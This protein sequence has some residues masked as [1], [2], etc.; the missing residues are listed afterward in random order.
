MEYVKELKPES[1]GNTAFHVA[2]DFSRYEVCKHFIEENVDLN[3]NDHIG[4]TPL[5]Y[6]KEQNEREI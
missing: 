1:D 3:I 4:R 5:E 6:A 2:I